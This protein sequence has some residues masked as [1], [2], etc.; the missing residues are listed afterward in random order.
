MGG[1]RSQTRRGG[2]SALRYSRLREES[3]LAFL[4]RVAERAG[5]LL[6]DARGIVLAGKADAKNRLRPELP[7]PLRDRVLCSLDLPC[8]AGTDGLRMA[9]ARAGQIV[10]THESR[11]TQSA[12]SNFMELLQKPQGEAGSLICYGISQTRAALEMG[13]V[14]T[15]LVAACDS[16]APIPW[17]Q[18]ASSSGTVVIGVQNFSAQ[19]V[20]F[21]S[22]FQVGG[23][24]RWPVDLDLLDV[25]DASNNVN[26]ACA[27][28]DCAENCADVSDVPTNTSHVELASCPSSS[29]STVNADKPSWMCSTRGCEKPSWNR[30]RGQYCSRACRDGFQ[31]AMS[32]TEAD[33][34][35]SVCPPLEEQSESLQISSG[36]STGVD[37]DA[38]GELSK[39]LEQVLAS[40]LGDQSQAEALVACTEVVLGEGPIEWDALDQAKDMLLGEGVPQEVVD[41]FGARALSM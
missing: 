13:A 17:S 2:Q 19:D 40:S 39:W 4:R 18:L 28:I 34:Y 25:D 7:Q 12:L 24:L 27:E 10:E 11:E 38:S 32:D 31:Q 21:C 35:T 20:L 15:L 30:S 14:E 3:D 1:T 5:R 26:I 29:T 16:T 6:G 8:D 41:A 23:I 9:A 22:N 33:C 36:Y 37:A